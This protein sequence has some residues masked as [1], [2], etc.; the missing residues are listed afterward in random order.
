MGSSGC[1]QPSIIHSSTHHPSIHPSIPTYIHAYT[2][3]HSHPY[4]YSSIH[5]TIHPPI[6]SPIHPFIYPPMY[7]FIPFQSF[8]DHLLRIYR[9]WHCSGKG[10]ITPIQILALPP[11]VGYFTPRSL[12]IRICVVE[13][14]TPLCGVCEKWM[15]ENERKP[16]SIVPGK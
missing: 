2:H 9:K 12:S 15:T 6:H 13:M 8:N 16:L 4:F 11:W 3:P 7:L 10:G 5:L 1:N 14:L